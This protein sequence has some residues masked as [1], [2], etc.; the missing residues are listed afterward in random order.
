MARSASRLA[1]AKTMAPSPHEPVPYVRL[2]DPPSWYA[3]LPANER[4]RAE[5]D[6]CHREGGWHV[7]AAESQFGKSSTNRAAAHS[8]GAQTNGATVR[9]PMAFCTAVKGKRHMLYASLCEYVGGLRL[10]NVHPREIFLAR[11]IAANGVLT[12]IVNNA[13]EML[14]VSQWSDLLGLHEYVLNRH[15]IKLTVILSGIYVKLSPASLP[16]RTRASD[17]Y[18][19]RVES[20]TEVPANTA[21]EMRTAM[22]IAFEFAAPGLFDP[23]E[24][25]C[26]HLV[27]ELLTAPEFDPYGTKCVRSKQLLD[28]V[29]R[30]KAV[31][32]RDPELDIEDV[33]RTA[34]AHLLQTRPPSA[35]LR[36]ASA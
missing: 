14:E 7:L 21:A 5:L 12:I 16:F 6:R 2:P 34:H 28:L 10:V 11:A 8:L 27:H 30:M 32:Q 15:G 23:S 3:R 13:H 31:R 24:A 19:E 25:S 18:R 9:I 22:K 4:W 33:V 35:P 29:R 26:H 1:A 20:Y 36:G 17:Q